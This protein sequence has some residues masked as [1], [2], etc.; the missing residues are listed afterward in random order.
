M[1]GDN[2]WMVEQL[3]VGAYFGRREIQTKFK[4]MRRE[5]L[6][7]TTQPCM[8][9]IKLVLHNQSPEVGR[10]SPSRKFRAHQDRDDETGCS[11]GLGWRDG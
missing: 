5:M 6:C 4:F 7:S 3:P 2:A 1:V 8:S 9:M 11:P 10:A